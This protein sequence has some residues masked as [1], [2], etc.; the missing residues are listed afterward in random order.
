MWNDCIHINFNTI[1]QPKIHKLGAPI[2]P[3]VSFYN[4]PLS[5]L[6]KILAH[7]LKPLANSSIRLKDTNDFKQHLKT[8]GHPNFPYHTSLDIKSL[9]TSCNMKKSLSTTILHFQDKPHLLPPNIS[10]STIQSLISFRLDNSYFEFNGQFYSQDTGGTMGSPL[11]VELA[12]IRVAEVENT[13]LTTYKDPPNTYRHFVDDGI[14]DFRDKSHADG[15][16]NYLNSLTDDLQYTIEYPSH[17]GSLPYMDI[18]IHADKS[19]FVYRKPTHTNLYV[20]YNSCAP[21]SSHQIP[22]KTSSQNGHP[23]DRVKRIMDSVKQKLENSNKLT[24]KQFNRQLKATTP[25]L[26]A[27]FPFHHTIT[28]KIKKSLASHDVKV[29][30]SSGTTLR[31]LL[32]KTKTTP[33]PHLTP[34]VIY[35]ISC[36][37]CTATY[38]GQTNR[39]LIKGWKN[40]NPTQDSTYTTQMT[41]PTTNLLL[42]TTHGPLDTR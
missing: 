12:E 39:P 40:M 20:R 29:K 23:P 9:Y 28:K 19:T 37:D 4:T 14:G 11:V 41:S 35:E 32:T 33:P 15:F 21:S 17:D 24:L 1:G 31:D 5:A 27:S 26:T 25:S 7:Y 36:N 38:N 3:V 42:S 10:A 8:T 30:S 18:L 6:H 22:Y 2:R 34:N 13:A 16:L